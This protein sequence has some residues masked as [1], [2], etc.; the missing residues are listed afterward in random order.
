[1]AYGEGGALLFYLG[2]GHGRIASYTAL[3][4][5]YGEHPHIRVMDLF[6]ALIAQ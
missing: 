6:G 4:S 3:R 5:G 2:S 1:M